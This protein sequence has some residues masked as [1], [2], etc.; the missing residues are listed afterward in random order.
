MQFNMPHGP[1]VWL[2]GDLQHRD[3]CES[4]ALLRRTADVG[5]GSPE[6]IIAAESRPGTIRHREIERLRRGA[7]LAAVISLCGSWCEG[8]LR[9]G[10]PLAG[11]TRLYWYEFPS[12]WRRQL[13]LHASGRCPEWAGADDC[14]WRV[15][16]GGSWG[17]VVVAAGS[18]D[19]FDALADVLRQAK[20]TAK[21][22]RPSREFSVNEPICAGIWGGG[23]LSDAEANRL[24]RFCARVRLSGAPVIALLDFPRC[25]RCDMARAAGAAAVLGKPWRNADLVATL[26]HV[27]DM[28]QVV[29]RVA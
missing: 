2:V 28:Q 8:E 29:A 25:D 1:K 22:I 16:D 20:L 15:A 4:V 24:E 6:V 19:T 21:W 14:G 17:R 12:W 5:P 26:E 7:P 13:E 23:Q 18:C 10:R 11:T 3:F 9:T 27:K